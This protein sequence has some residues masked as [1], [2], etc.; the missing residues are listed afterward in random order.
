MKKNYA[1]VAGMLLVTGL[2]PGLAA[3]A[4]AQTTPADTTHLKYEEELLPAAALP[5]VPRQARDQWKLGLNNF[6]VNGYPFSQTK[7]VPGYYTRYGLH[8]AYERWLGHAWAGQ[9]ELSPAIIH[10][11]AEGTGGAPVA[12]AQ[13]RA[14]LAG[15]Y[16]Y[17]LERR[18][19]RGHRTAG[20]SANYFAL[21]LGLGLSKGPSETPF[22]LLAD[23]TGPATDAALLY[24]VQRRL[25]RFGFVDLNAGVSGVLRAGRVQNFGPVASLRIGVALPTIARTA[26][27][28][29]QPDEVQALLPRFFVGA[30]FGDARYHTHYTRANPYPTSYQETTNGYEKYVIYLPY[31]P[32]YNNAA[33]GTREY[34]NDK[35][36]YVYGGYYLKP[37]LALQV[38]V[39]YGASR[40]DFGDGAVGI[41]RAGGDYY[42]PRNRFYDESILAVPVQVRYAV[43]RSFQ[44]RLQVEVVGGLTPVWSGVRFREY[45]TA[46][47]AVTDQVR[48]EFERRALGLTA[49]L[50]GALSYGLGRRR[51]VQAT[52]DYGLQEDLHNLFS[53]PERPATYAKVGLR[54]RFGYR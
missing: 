52:V 18:L 4:A 51:R 14:Q 2:L 53:S 33:I 47:Y 41:R 43:T 5:P 45:E 1:Y 29:A 50:G 26:P 9:L 8:L 31:G 34:D 40:R 27:Q 25:G 54:Y 48:F 21:A 6:L 10:Y 11:R 19:R 17:N 20:F 49:N 22:H 28:E 38:G 23:G 3:P 44:R 36:Y 7:D 32:G 30:Q 37:R 24:G 46:G 35:T 12:S 39:Q 13:L 15:R 16:Y 42:Y